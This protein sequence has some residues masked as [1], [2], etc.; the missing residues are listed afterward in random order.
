MAEIQFGA[1]GGATLSN[2]ISTH[3]QNLKRLAR[4]DEGQALVLTALGLVVLMLM[5]GL[6]VDVGYLRYQKQQMQRAADAGALAG[7]SALQY[8]GNYTN[9]AQ[10]DTIANGFSNGINGVVVTVNSPPQ[11]VGD[12]FVG[13]AGYVEVIVAQ[14]Q[15]TFFMRVGGFNTVAVQSRAVASSLGPPSDCIYALDPTDAQSFLV[16]GNVNVSSTCGIYVG[17]AS[18]GA[19]RKNGNSGIVQASYVGIVGDESQ[20]DLNGVF[21]QNSPNQQP[22][23][24]IA[25]VNDPLA[26][27]CPTVAACPDLNP[28]QPGTRSGNTFFPGRWV[29]GISLGANNNYT[30]TP[31]VYVLIGGGLTVTGSPT[32]TGAGVTFYNTFDATHPYSGISMAG[33]PTVTLSAP[34]VGDTAG[35]L[36]FQDRRVPVGSSDSN[37]VGS[38]AQ[39]YT[40]AIYFPTTTITFKG[41]PSLASTSTIMVGWKL[42]FRGDTSFSNYT[43]LPSGGGPITSATL[44]E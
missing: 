13:Q 28:S 34:T 35:M 11:T 15:P 38:S 42:D 17:S 22:V 20:S 40:G 21:S 29:G 23:T 25:P 36:F 2:P 5:A 31:G 1:H 43:F 33:S 18:S 8:G 44:V 19:L 26:S 39:G 41:T 6:G 32:I 3:K 10:N 9:A 4:A 12:P 7:A 30:F 24:N 27:V 16:D 37:F 14:P